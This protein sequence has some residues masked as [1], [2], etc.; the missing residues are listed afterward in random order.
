L[1]DAPVVGVLGRLDEVK[2]HLTLIEAAS[3][4]AKEFPSLSVRCAGS[5]PNGRLSALAARAMDLG[6]DSRVRF[7]G[8]VPDA[9]AFIDACRIG[10]VASSGSEAVSRAALEWM[11][12]GRPVVAT[13]VGCLPDL[14]EDG[15]T[16]L[17]VPPN[18]PAALADALARL[19]RDGALAAEMGRRGRE[20]FLAQFSLDRFASETERVYGS[21]LA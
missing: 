2:G 18:D 15:E 3:R 21:L 4:I 13:R 16:G 9:G 11:R 17:L 20:R 6:L 14:V 1:P 5:D 7:L 12:Q 10:V 8:R 19:L